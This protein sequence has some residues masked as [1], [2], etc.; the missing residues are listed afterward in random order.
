MKEGIEKLIKYTIWLAIILFCLRCGLSWNDIV[1]NISVYDI[2]GYAGEA[3]GLAIV[4]TIAYERWLWRI[5]PF[6]CVPALKKA[7]KGKIKSSYDSVERDVDLLIKQSLLSVHVIMISNESKSNSLAASVIQINGEYCLVY[8][9]L[10]TPQS[11]YR[12]RSEVHYGT[13]I[14]SICDGGKLNGVY[15]TDRKTIGDMKFVAQ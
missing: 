12:N 3:V 15:Y 10:N 1:K 13:A 4:I 8:H 7:Y 9:Y 11:Q 6:E 5:N 14:L 2:F